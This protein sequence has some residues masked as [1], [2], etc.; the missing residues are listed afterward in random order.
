VPFRG[1]AVVLVSNAV[2][3]RRR[4]FIFMFVLMDEGVM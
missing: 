4:N 1:A 2:K 3:R